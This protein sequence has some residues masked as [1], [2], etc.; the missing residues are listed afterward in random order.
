MTTSVAPSHVTFIRPQ[1]PPPLRIPDVDLNDGE[2]PSSA[3]PVPFP[4]ISQR[5]KLYRGVGTQPWHHKAS[6]D[7]DSDSETSQT[8][9]AKQKSPVHHNPEIMPGFDPKRTYSESQLY[10]PNPSLLT[11]FGTPLIRKKSGQVVKSALKSPST[12]SYGGSS[13]RTSVPPTPTSDKSVK[14]DEQLEHVR[15]FLKEQRPAAVSREGSPHD[16]ETSDNDTLGQ[17]SDGV[18]RSSEDERLRSKLVM[19]TVN[20]P[21]RN[22]M[23]ST[24][25]RL[26]DLDIRLEQVALS[27]DNRA[28]EGTVLVRNIAY[29]KWIAVRFTYDWWQ[30]TSEVTAKY[31]K[32]F[33]E[34]NTDLFSFTI[35]LPEVTK[36]IEDKRLFFALRYTAGGREC[37]DNNRG[38]NY[39]LRFKTE[40]KVPAVIASSSSS[41]SSP[42]SSS[43]AINSSADKSIADLKRELEK[44]AR[45]NADGDDDDKDPSDVRSWNVLTAKLRAKNMHT[46]E[47]RDIK[48]GLDLSSRYN[49]NTSSKERWQA[50]KD[51]P[52]YGGPPPETVAIPF[53]SGRPTHIK[54]SSTPALGQASWRS[55]RG[56]PRDH[57]SESTAS[58]PKFFIDPR[59][60]RRS[61]G[62]IGQSSPGGSRVR[63]HQRGGYF[64]SYMEGLSGPI[65]TPTTGET[66]S[67]PMAS[68][69]GSL[70][71]STSSSVDSAVTVTAPSYPSEKRDAQSQQQHQPMP[72]VTIT[73]DN[74]ETTSESESTSST[75]SDSQVTG[76]TSP[77]NNEDASTMVGIEQQQQQQQARSAIRFNSYPMDRTYLSPATSNTPSPSGSLSPNAEP[78]SASLAVPKVAIGGGSGWPLSPQGSSSSVVSTPSI[79]S[80]SSPSQCP[81]S[82]S[83]LSDSLRSIH[84]L[85]PG[86]RPTLDS[87]DY[88]YFLQ[89]FCYYT[90]SE[91]P[92]D[93][94]GMNLAYGSSY[95]RQTQ[96]DSLPYRRHSLETV[97]T[98]YAESRTGIEVAVS[99]GYDA[100][101]V[102]NEAPWVDER[103]TLGSVE[104]RVP[105]A[106]IVE[107]SAD[108]AGWSSGS[109]HTTP[110]R[111]PKPAKRHL[112]MTAIESSPSKQSSTTPR[113]EVAAVDVEATPRLTTDY[114]ARPHRGSL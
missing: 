99:P 51:L 81:S 93:R 57:G 39:Q 112:V 87:V 54:S 91:L 95:H 58:S 7:S 49:F 65:L 85:A 111:S 79:T 113:P 14:F 35:R 84:Q 55:P 30:T 20:I 27:H 46:E 26:G 3:A 24:Q 76:T 33:P 61:G 63:H 42:R 16:S 75:T 5:R 22:A 47:S 83:E 32:S 31:S 103:S 12:S 13:P 1:A 56:S 25:Q 102:I 28:V 48:K 100:S 23:E 110:T 44:V 80:A 74:S 105:N 9:T 97:P 29:E 18:Y 114:F 19:E 101:V 53:P 50:P 38:S 108:G 92:V 89:R 82:P 98:V 59:D 66:L 104:S 37:W 109:G 40:T 90:G 45:A 107:A 64:D 62:G 15:L 70:D 36:R 52:R 60:A 68:E 11:A 71:M 2:S 78:T 72:S 73:E 96:S 94:H 34:E 69:D 88:S 77:M 43:W 17:Q 21:L 6:S 86:N 41:S 4:R 106:T 8:R 67:T 10:S